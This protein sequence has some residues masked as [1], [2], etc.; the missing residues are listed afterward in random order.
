MIASLLYLFLGAIF[1][2]TVLRSSRAPLSLGGQ[3]FWGIPIGIMLLACWTFLWAVTITMQD[4]ALIGSC[5]SAAAYIFYYFNLDK[6]RSSVAHDWHQL[7]THTD[8]KDIIAWAI[9]LIPWL[10]Y[11]LATIPNLLFFR[12]G[13]LVAGW[14][15]I[16]GDWAVHLRNSTFLAANDKLRLEHPLFSGTDF[17]YPYLSSYLSAILQRL[18][19]PV[20]RSLTWPTMALFAMLPGLLYILGQKLTK[21]RV[22]GVLFTYIVLLAGGM[23]IAYLLQDLLAGKYFWEASSY[24]PTL[25][26]D[27]RLNGSYTNSGIWFMNFIM[28]EFLP[29]RA[30]LAG[31]PIALYVLYS[32]WCNLFIEKH[33]DT[34]QLIVTG[35]LFGI[36]PLLHT[37]SFIAMGIIV[38][39]LFL[40]RFVQAIQTSYTTTQIKSSL[41]EWGGHA[42]ALLAP[43]TLLG[44]GLLF[45]FVF[46]PQATGSFIHRIT[47]WMP[48]QE[49]P[50]DN[51]IRYWLR[52]AGPIIIL[53]IISYFWKGKPFRSLLLAGTI[54]WVACNFLSFQPWHYDNLKIM[55]YWYILWAIPVATLLASIPRRLAI[56]TIGAFILLTGAGLADALSVT[57]STQQGIGLADKNAVTFATAVQTATYNQPDA[58]FISA[59]NHDNP[60]SLLSGRRLYVGYEGWLWTYGIIAN[61]R[62]E[63]VREMY[64][65]TDKGIALIKEKGIDYIALGPQ[66]RAVYK[67]NEITL[68]AMYPAVVQK[69]GYLLLRVK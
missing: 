55:T 41:K 5:A 52:N 49:L 23:G 28:S 6:H 29:Q 60:L 69:N 38:P 24:S 67:P 30:F 17:H 54:L 56:V 46:D 2:F 31:L 66:E 48:N 43:A 9:V 4:W 7:I 40:A 53:G 47:W 45:A 65:A 63:E 18:G 44:F 33:P 21:N 25:Y 62:I 14:I 58:L 13:D 22:A 50:L 12:E 34:K 59:T 20:D 39:A 37:H 35:L 51:P 64:K 36:L 3:L 61:D 16:W 19:L 57:S 1:G 68:R 15:N 26:T 10:L 8:K 27:Y 42:F 11:S 32:T